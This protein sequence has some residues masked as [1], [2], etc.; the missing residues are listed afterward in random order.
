MSVLIYIDHTN[1]Q[2]KKGSLEALCYGAA[3]AKQLGTP[4]EALL[5][6]TVNDDLPALGKYGVAKIYHA[7]NPQFNSADAAAIA[8]AIADS[9]KDATVVVFTQNITSK[10]VAPQLAAALKAGLVAGV[11]A[12][13]ETADGFTVKKTVFSGKA[14]AKVKI[15]TA[16]KIIS[17]NANSF[18]ISETSDAA[19]EIV[20]IDIAPLENKINTLSVNK[21]EG[22][23]PLTEAEIVV[24][25]GHG[26]KAAENW[27]LIM[28]LAQAF[29]GAFACTRP[30]SDDGWRP[31]HEH[32]GQT[33]T[34][35]APNLYIGIGVSGAIQHL[36]GVSNSKT[37]AA[38]NK[39]AEAPIFKVA[40]YGIVGDLFEVAP[41]L[42]EAVKK[43][44]EKEKD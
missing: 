12:L 22:E 27:H 37:I 14:F 30:V 36:G 35:V 44:K 25:G 15:N 11:V 16:V 41:K 13:P 1:G 33:G 38:I 8:K 4:A 18:G 19:A 43:F 5:L 39:D 7:A 6:G 2:I 31:M 40:D 9:L 29:G 23:V 17:L 28:D 3:L 32:V 10:S 24:C 21:I 42:I 20:P 26:L 34:Q